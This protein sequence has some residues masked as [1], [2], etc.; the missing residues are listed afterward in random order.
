MLQEQLHNEHCRHSHMP[1]HY[2]LCGVGY[3][4]ILLLM[5]AFAAHDYVVQ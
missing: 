2:G 5:H 4:L 3:L 1:E